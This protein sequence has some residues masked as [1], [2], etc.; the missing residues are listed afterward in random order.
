MKDDYIAFIDHVMRK[1]GI[2]LKLYKERQMKRRITSLR[3]KRGYPDFKAYFKALETNEELLAE[4]IDRITINVSEFYR[5]PKRWQVLK[6]TI[7]PS[8]LKEQTSPITIWSAACSTGEEPYSMAIMLN[9]YFPD[10]NFQIIATDID[11]NALAK[12]KMGIY[13]KQA[14]KEVPVLLKEKYLTEKAD[15]YSVKPFLKQYITYKKH[16]L[17]KDRYPQHV[18]LIIC[19]NVLIYFTDEAKEF[20]YGQFANALRTEGVLFVGSTEQIFN[21]AKY[22]FRLMDTFFYHKV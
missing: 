5:N 16:N 4:F 22:Q 1:T 17:L 20:I 14:L 10:V 3:N 18:D 15:F 2:D 21:P 13:Q 12:A 11:N 9:E 19:R 8:L 7:L 6:E